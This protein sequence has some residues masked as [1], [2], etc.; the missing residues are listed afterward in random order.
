M[1]TARIVKVMVNR[2]ALPTLTAY[3]KSGR[4]PSRTLADGEAKLLA[5]VSMI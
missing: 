4:S 1:R 2:F 3:S 5:F